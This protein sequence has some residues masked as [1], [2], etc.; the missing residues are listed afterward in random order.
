MRDSAVIGPKC[1]AVL[2]APGKNKNEKNNDVGQLRAGT[3]GCAQSSWDRWKQVIWLQP[4]GLAPIADWSKRR[5]SLVRSRV[6]E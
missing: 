4:P 1:I 2:A 6:L 3:V 5:C